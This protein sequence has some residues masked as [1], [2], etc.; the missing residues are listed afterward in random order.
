MKMRQ[1]WWNIGLPFIITL[2]LSGCFSKPSQ[3]SLYSLSPVPENK[4]LP[5]GTEPF[6]AMT[7]IMPVRVAPQLNQTGILVKVSPQQTHISTLHLWS[8]PL[9]KQITAIVSEN[10]SRQLHSANIA[11]YPG[12][13]YGK[14][15]YSV[16]I[17][18]KQFSPLANQFVL[19]AN[20]TINDTLL[21]K[22]LKRAVFSTTLT[23]PTERYDSYVQ[24][25][26]EALS[27]LSQ[28][29]AG[30]LRAIDNSTLQENVQ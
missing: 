13:R 29:I 17:D 30:T 27:H 12:P 25:A 8:A 1:S 24:S 20:W 2:L 22:I 4:S 15:I 28:E 26:S 21:K 18:I 23:S 16:E 7:M 14:V 9:D 11:M 19:Q 6:K 3:V 10:I 5:K